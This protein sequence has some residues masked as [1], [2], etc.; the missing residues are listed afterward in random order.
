METFQVYILMVNI[1]LQESTSHGI[2][3]DNSTKFGKWVLHIG[4]GNPT[5]VS[6]SHVAYF[7]WVKIPDDLLLRKANG[8]ID[9]IK[10]SIRYVYNDC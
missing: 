1:R 4:N 3:N 10:G 8:E 9:D 2:T 7:D 5:S 6:I